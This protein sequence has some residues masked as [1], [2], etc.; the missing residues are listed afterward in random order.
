MQPARIR[1][2]ISHSGIERISVWNTSL[3]GGHLRDDPYGSVRSGISAEILRLTC[4][5]MFAFR[6]RLTLGLDQAT[7]LVSGEAV[8]AR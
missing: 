1:Q 6:P 8:A 4:V 7:Y 5:R 3:P 2:P